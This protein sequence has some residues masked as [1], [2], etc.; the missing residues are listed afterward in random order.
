MKYDIETKV[1]DNWEIVRELGSGVF[2]DVFE[3]RKMIF[4]L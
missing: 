3:I 2:G 4:G 1:I